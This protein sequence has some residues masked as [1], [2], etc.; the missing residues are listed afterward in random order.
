M[1]PE[2]GFPP[3]SLCAAVKAN[4]EEWFLSKV[5][6]GSTTQSSCLRVR[7]FENHCE[8]EMLH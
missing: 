1:L 5:Q 3:K 4:G 7:R 8:R 6:T 2:Q